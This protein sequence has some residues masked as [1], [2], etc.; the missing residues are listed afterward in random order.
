MSDVCNILFEPPQSDYCSDV[1]PLKLPPVLTKFQTVYLTKIL[2]CILSDCRP[3][4]Q[5][6][7][8]CEN[9]TLT[10]TWSTDVVYD[11]TVTQIPGDIQ[12][13]LRERFINADGHKLLTLI[14]ISRQPP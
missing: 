3:L 7:L 12:Q 6:K 8:S 4:P 2:N 13:R 14:V 10:V 5:A 1:T 9:D 11:A